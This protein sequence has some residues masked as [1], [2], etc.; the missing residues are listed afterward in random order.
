[1]YVASLAGELVALARADGA[2]KW[3]VPTDYRL[4]PHHWVPSYSPALAPGGALLFAGAG[5]RVY[6][7][8]NADAARFLTLGRL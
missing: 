2:V 6:G 7:L 5:G 1:M 4:P 3:R 8:A